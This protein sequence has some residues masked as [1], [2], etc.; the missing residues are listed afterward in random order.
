MRRRTRAKTAKNNPFEVD[1]VDRCTAF[2]GIVWCPTFLCFFQKTSD[3]GIPRCYGFI[4]RSTHPRR[5]NSRFVM[6]C[7]FL[8]GF[9]RRSELLANAVIFDAYPSAANGKKREHVAQRLHM[10]HCATCLKINGVSIA[11]GWL[12]CVKELS[13]LPAYNN[14]VSVQCFVKQIIFL[15]PTDK[16]SIAYAA[17]KGH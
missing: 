11:G 8:V 6:R 13:V 14:P 17:A 16:I 7:Q 4:S 10:G 12:V 2:S 3:F 15:C 1:K 9:M 5:N